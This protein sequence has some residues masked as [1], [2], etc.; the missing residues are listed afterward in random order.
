MKLEPKRLCNPSSNYW[1]QNSCK[2]T[3]KIT[4][5]DGFAVH[6]QNSSPD[7]WGNIVARNGF[8]ISE[9]RQLQQNNFAGPILYYYEIT[10]KSSLLERQV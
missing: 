2:A 8:L 9:C 4:Q 6:V 10:T 5:P 1:N 3:M 7:D